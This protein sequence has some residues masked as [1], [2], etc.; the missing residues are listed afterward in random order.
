MAVVLGAS[1]RSPPAGVK[2][3]IAKAR[4]TRSNILRAD[5]VGSATCE[6]ATAHTRWLHG[7][8]RSL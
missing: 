5:Y 4:E 1:Y 7:R 3:G 6:S 8:G 2:V